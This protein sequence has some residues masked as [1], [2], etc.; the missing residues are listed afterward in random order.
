MDYDRIERILAL[1]SGPWYRRQA[2]QRAGL[3]PGAQVLD[4]GI[5]TGLV[6]QEALKL[7]APTGS[8]I[9]V[10][11]SPGMMG[12]ANLPGVQLLQGFAEKLPRP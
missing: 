9:G 1:G 5:G 10:D 2:L 4:V 12:Q 6:A 11:P 3:L 7:I 8:L